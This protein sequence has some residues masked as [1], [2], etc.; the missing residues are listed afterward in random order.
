MTTGTEI[1]KCKAAIQKALS[2]IGTTNGT[3]PPSSRRNIFPTLYEFF[4]AD[5]MRSNINKRYDVAKA[6]L[7]EVTGLNLDELE[8]SSSQISA[9]TEHLDLLCKKAAG[10]ST[11]DKTMLRNELTK[12]YGVNTADQIIEASSKPRKG[13]VTLSA[14]MK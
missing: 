9:S 8:D 6:Q 7:I 11:I 1:I 10:S 5:T 13:A 2:K 3:A 14:V 12:R 4:V